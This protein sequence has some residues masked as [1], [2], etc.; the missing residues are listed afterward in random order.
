MINNIKIKTGKNGPRHDP[1]EY[2]IEVAKPKRLESQ[3]SY[4]CQTSSP[5]KRQADSKKRV[6]YDKDDPFSVLFLTEKEKLAA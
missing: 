6:K 5:A 2:K 3:A 4:I 1:E